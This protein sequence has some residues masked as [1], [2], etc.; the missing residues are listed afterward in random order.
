VLIA[1]GGSIVHRPRTYAGGQRSRGYRFDSDEDH[2]YCVFVVAFPNG[3]KGLPG[4]VYRAPTVTV[5]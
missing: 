4:V 2:S 3:V 1:G 5:P